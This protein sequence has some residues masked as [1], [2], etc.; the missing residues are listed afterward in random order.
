MNYR[1]M[2]YS[3]PWNKLLTSAI[4]IRL[5]PISV[6]FILC[7]FLGSCENKSQE[8]TE[9]NALELIVLGTTQ[10]AGYP[11]AGCKKECCNKYHFG[12]QLKRM[13][14][15]LG[16]I[17][18]ENEELWMFDATPDF[19]EQWHNLQEAAS[20][21][22]LVTPSGI[23]LSHAHIGHYLG[24]AQLGHEAMG[25][26]NVPVFA[27]PRMLQFLTENGPWSQLVKYQNIS[28]K[29]IFN[30]APIQVNSNVMVQPFVVPHRDE[31]SETIGFKIMTA[32]KKILFIPDI[33]KW[34]KWEYAITDQIKSVD[35]AFIDG[36]FYDNEGLPG[37][38]MSLVPHPFI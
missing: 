38:D 35:M 31:Y 9:H 10:D 15:C 30:Q 32:N 6:L 18:H 8:K 33:D 21:N 5:I 26:K 19:K 22:T 14:S 36:T 3:Y 25:A 13:T 12:H 34:N 24:L 2:L 27:M 17:D 4:T 1:S 7:L 23:F 28:L 20:F 29:A 11:Q 16:L 37:R